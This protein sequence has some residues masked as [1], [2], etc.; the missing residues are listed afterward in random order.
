MTRVIFCQ[1]EKRKENPQGEVKAFG[2]YSEITVRH[3][4]LKLPTVIFV[5]GSVMLL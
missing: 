3:S 1:D 2:Y 4:T 5:S